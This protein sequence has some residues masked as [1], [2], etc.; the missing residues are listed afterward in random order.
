VSGVIVPHHLVAAPL[1]AGAFAGVGRPVTTV[2]L[3]VPD[4]R[5]ASPH[6]VSASLASWTTAGGRIEPHPE[7]A[8]QLA[9]EGLV[10]L[11]E[12]A[13]AREHAVVDLVPFIARAFPDARLLPLRFRGLACAAQADAA[14]GLGRRLAE[15]LEPE[16]VVVASV[17]FVHGAT[18]AAARA[19]DERSEQALRSLEPARACEA[20][21]DSPL[22]LVALLA[23]G[24]AAGA[25]H[26]ALLQRSD[27]HAL[28]ASP[29]DDVVSYQTAYLQQGRHEPIAVLAVGDIMLGRGVT[30]TMRARN[31]FRYPLAKVASVLRRA[32]LV[33]ATLEAPLTTDCPTVRRGLELCADARSLDALVDAGIDVV[34]V[35][36]NHARDQGET[37]LA[38]GVRRLRAAGIAV[39]GYDG[40]VTVERKGARFAILAYDAVRGPFDSR[41]MIRE[42]GAARRLHDT[43]LV[44]M[45][46]GR[47]HRTEPHSLQRRLAVAAATAGADLIVG[48]HPHAVQPLEQIGDATVAFSLGNFVFDPMVPE[49]ARRGAAGVFTFCGGSLARA[50]LVSVRIASDGA[51]SWLGD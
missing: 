1:L 14:T 16:A 7:L 4:H 11:D 42:I 43:I 30:A 48:S 25:S 34:S 12:R 37:A 41:V 3:L 39:A 31:D 29:S 32:D 46:W 47:E 13:F 38:A 2:V 20:E 33:L 36:T 10:A 45:H 6:P 26:L 22:A 15:L 51:P 24:N 35:A 9:S 28:G 50:G 19:L 5:N 44:M 27:S 23:H 21:V 17:D 18:Q 40:L 8:A 49:T